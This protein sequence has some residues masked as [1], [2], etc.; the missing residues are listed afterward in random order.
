M[1][2][3]IK[4]YKKIYGKLIAKWV[5]INRNNKLDDEIRVEKHHI[6]PRSLG[7]SNDPSNIVKVPLR[8]HII[9]HQ[10]LVCIYPNNESMIYSAN[11]MMSTR[12]EKLPNTRMA[13][14]TRELMSK[15]RKEKAE[16][17][18][19]AA[20]K[21]LT[22]R[23]RPDIERKHLS[24]ARIKLYQNMTVEERLNLPGFRNHH[25]DK[26]KELISKKNKERMKNKTL[27]ERAVTGIRVINSEGK[28]FESISEASR[29]YNVSPTTISR[30]IKQDKAGLK[31]SENQDPNKSIVKRV[32]GPDGTI[33]NSIRECSR[34]TGHTVGTI[35]R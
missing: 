20:R 27:E 31:F 6:I 23:K 3:N 25:S 24:E 2:N 12:N 35:R 28:T 22:G 30:W 5:N 11:M 29:Y 4:W 18:L 7:G 19:S 8:V 15:I 10:L 34:I 33:Y 14:W 17:R 26:S 1:N 13:A 32:K 16:E 9:L 21:V